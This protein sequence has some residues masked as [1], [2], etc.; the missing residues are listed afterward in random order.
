MRSATPLACQV[1]RPKKKRAVEFTRLLAVPGLKQTWQLLI[2]K[3]GPDLMFKTT[4]LETAF[5]KLHE[6]SWAHIVAQCID[7]GLG[8]GVETARAVTLA[9][10]GE[11]STCVIGV[12]SS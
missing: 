6:A 4:E 11:K 9:R 5:F 8:L 2:S 12:G 7:L 10:S 1:T 3:A